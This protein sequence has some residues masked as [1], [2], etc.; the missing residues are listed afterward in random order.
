[1]EELKVALD[2][3]DKACAIIQELVAQL[4]SKGQSEDMSKKAEE[5]AAKTGMSYEDA[6]GIIKEASEKG[7]STDVLIKAAS[8]VR[9]HDSFGRVASVE[10]EFAKTGSVAT[11]N[12][13]EKQAALMD[14]LGL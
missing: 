10:R 12:F 2:M 4:Q 9:N 11:D 8:I 14:E 5:L 13:L 6:S 7:S 3:L 1:M